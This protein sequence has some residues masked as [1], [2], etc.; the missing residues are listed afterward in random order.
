VAKS[1]KWASKDAEQGFM[2]FSPRHSAYKGGHSTLPE[3]QRMKVIF[4]FIADIDFTALGADT[5][6]I[7]LSIIMT[8]WR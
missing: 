7:L 5:R 4:I 1:A 2:H 3:V 8:S 6:C